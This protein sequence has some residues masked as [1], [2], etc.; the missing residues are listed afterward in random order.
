MP[1]N[2]SGV[3]SKPAGTTAVPN[4]TIESAK[5]NQVVDDLVQDANN[6]R[7]VT[8]GGTG[9]TSVATAQSALQVDPKVVYVTKPGDYTTVLTDQNAVISFSAAAT[10]TLTTAATLGANWHVRIV[11][12]GGTVIVDPSGSEL[13]NG[14]LQLRVLQ[15]FACDIICTGTEFKATLVIPAT[16]IASL[17]G[18]RNAIINGNCRFIVRGG[19]TIAPGASAYVF[20]RF[21]V[22]NNTNQ[23]VTVNQAAFTPGQVLVPGNPRTKMRFTFGTAPTSGTLRVE[24]RIENVYKFSGKAASAR[25]YFTGPTG[26]ET[27]SCEIVQSFGVG[28][29][30]SAPVATAAAS[31]DIP[32]IYDASTQL[33]RAQFV[34]PSVTGKVLGTSND[35]ISLAWLLSPRQSGAY[36]IA[37][38]SFV[39]GDASFEDDPFSEIDESLEKMRC[40]RF[41]NFY[42]GNIYSFAGSG[43]TGIRRINLHWSTTMRAVPNVTWQSGDVFGLDERSAS[44]ARWFTDPGNNTFDGR[45]INAVLADAEL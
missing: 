36:E 34:V 38:V 30:P 17:T 2:G 15:G 5:F 21:L 23:S 18:T 6:A 25:A 32:K 39:E 22:T 24:Q 41:C 35:Y 11:A 26:N 37:R 7:P 12:D 43:T 28:G 14:A 19:K 20:D 16:A 42:D 44:Y 10:L 29:S 31:L 9:G 45:S 4:T 33:R 1:R 40:E 27:L 8:A 3:Y 13:I